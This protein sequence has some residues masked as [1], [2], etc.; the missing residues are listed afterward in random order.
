MSKAFVCYDETCDRRIKKP[1]KPM[2]KW[3]VKWFVTAL[4][5]CGCL[6]SVATWGWRWLRTPIVLEQT[7]ADVA[8]AQSNI[9]VISKAIEQHGY[10]LSNLAANAARQEQWQINISKGVNEQNV[11]LGKI[12]QKLD[13]LSLSK[14]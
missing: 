12:E 6:G 1:M 2:S 3:P 14:K 7:Q 13:D 8:T 4:V 5:G 10:A 11:T 9:V